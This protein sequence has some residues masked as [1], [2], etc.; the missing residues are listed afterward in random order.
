M[1]THKGFT[2]TELLIGNA[3]FLMILM[4]TANLFTNVNRSINATNSEMTK[5]Q[6]IARAADKISPYL[7]ESLRFDMGRSDSNHLS[8]VLPKI[9]RFTKRYKVPLENG[10][11][12]TFYLSDQSGS[13]LTTG[14]YL[15]RSINSIPDESWSLQDRPGQAPVAQL[16]FAGGSVEF[17]FDS[18]ENPKL[19]GLR[20]SANADTE[21][22]SPSNSI[23]MSISPRNSQ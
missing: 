22:S 6:L 4:I 11:T 21:S 18:T 10:D 17:T 16:S 9:D 1:K 20:F 3:L 5:T 13:P 12:V 15:W 19:V 23:E 14:S 7:R 2:T 8:L